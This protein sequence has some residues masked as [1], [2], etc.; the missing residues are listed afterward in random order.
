MYLDSSTVQ[1]NGKSYTRHLL[2]ECFRENGQIKHRTIANLSRCTPEEIEAIRLALKH[3]EQIA[4]LGS[5]RENLQ[6][7]LGLSCGAA[8]ALHT[9]AKD[10]GIVKALGPTQQGKLALWQV[11]ARVIDQGSRLSAVRLAGSHAACDILGLDTFNENDLY[12]NLD[13]LAEHQAKIEDRLFAGIPEAEEPGLYLYDVTSSY[14]EGEF[15]ELGAFGYNRDGKKGKKQIVIGLLC[16][17]QGIPLSIEV[18]PG[19]TGDPKTVASQVKK[20]VERFGGGR[21]TLV[22]DRG[23][24]RGPQIDDLPE[25]FCYITAITKQQVEGLLVSGVLQMSLFDNTV[26]EV[27]TDNGIRYVM[28]RNPMRA[29]ELVA[30]R[31]SK[32][33]V[34]NKAAATS[35]AYLAEHPRAKPDVQQRKLEAKAKKLKIGPWASVVVE[36][37]VLSIKVDKAALSDAGRFDGCYVIKTNLPAS[38]ASKETVHGRYKDLAL[39]EHGFRT[40]KTAELEMRPVNV[41]LESRTRGHA[42]V[43]MLAYR[44]TQELAQRWAGLDLT[45]QEGIDRLSLITSQD[46]IIKGKVAYQTIPKPSESGRQLLAAARVTLPSALPSQGVTVTTKRKLQ[47]RRL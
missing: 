21:L 14:L 31:Q 46:V 27:L 43:V 23:M 35:T 28:R 44:I 39:I 12:A 9:V 34:L 13:W 42:F 4:N 26:T 47:S 22:G 2:R 18:F 32:Q 29:E 15:N 3:K 11:Y 17:S 16:N 10:L 33:A 19:N 6:L 24:I 41:R 25:G 5:L 30:S 20:V 1:R 8:W 7:R 36:G 37:R 38:A 45:V 40:C